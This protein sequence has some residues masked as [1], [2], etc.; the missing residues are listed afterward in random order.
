[1]YVKSVCVIT[2]VICEKNDNCVCSFT[3]QKINENKSL[4]KIIMCAFKE[5][6]CA[7]ICARL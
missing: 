3:I 5:V 7:T 1:M 2:I 4:L 6:K